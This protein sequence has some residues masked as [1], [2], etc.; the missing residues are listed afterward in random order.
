MSARGAGCL[1]LVC[2]LGCSGRL[3]IYE[4]STPGGDT[5]GF[6][7]A[8]SSGGDRFGGG[9]AFLG[10]GGSN[11]GGASAAGLTGSAG[12]AGGGA[13]GVGAVA[14]AAGALS[15]SG[16]GGDLGAAGDASQT[17]CSS[18]ADCP[19][20]SNACVTALCAV[21]LCETSNVPPNKLFVEDSPADCHATSA[22]DG[23]GHATRVVDQNDVP[24]PSNPCLQG[25]CNG[26]GVPGTEATAAG[27]PCDTPPGA[28][29]CDGAG[30][31]V[32]CLLTQDCPS[33]LSCAATHQCVNAP[34][35]DLDCGGVCP[36]CANGK[37]CLQDQDCN[38]NAC[39]GVSLICIADQCSDH[40]LD[41]NEPD[42]DCGGDNCRARCA[43]GQ[44][45]FAD[46]DCAS[47]ACDGVSQRCVSGQCTDHRQDGKETDLD[48]G[49]GTCP[50]CA[51]DKHCLVNADCAS[52][53]CSNGFPTVCL[54]H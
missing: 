24:T 16:S 44:N 43:L 35:T 22:C 13:A 15:T 10:E 25:T 51:F 42:L 30:T 27:A 6:S 17:P 33:G 45:C 7:G 54:L 48:C 39:D 50:T 32:Q 2:L 14:G 4:G 52:G 9:G 18:V 19:K 23:Q 5:G 53:H 36:P 38:S 21:G 1:A 11:A 47:G 12:L 34:C 3:T 46:S 26:V 37:K 8:A 31:C 40:R 49:G 29:M 28:V 20:S 41:G